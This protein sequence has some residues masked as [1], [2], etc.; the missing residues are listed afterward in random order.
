[1]TAAPLDFWSRRR[2]AVRAEQAA[3]D[4]ARQAD[5]AASGEVCARDAQV[6]VMQAK[7]EA[8]ILSELGL[9]DPELMQMGDDFSAFMQKAVPEALRR[10]ALRQ[11]WRSN[12]VLA[13]LD[14]LVDFGEDFTDTAMV[15]PGMQTSY[16]VG[17]GLLRHVIAT[18]EA[19]QGGAADE[20]DAAPDVMAQ[21]TGDAASLAIAA[22]SD[23]APAD[24]EA[25]RE[26]SREMEGELAGDTTEAAPRPRRH[27]RFSFET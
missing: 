26:P 17:Q 13:N 4:S 16:V 1:M 23:E 10:R 20:A 7:S 11:L 22:P 12:P 14:G 5:V 3:L 21:A 6:D 24:N 27:M 19:A 2:A 18:T 9:K 25:G 15:V 8:E